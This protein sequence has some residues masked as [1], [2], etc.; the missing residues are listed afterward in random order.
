MP[1]ING[2]SEGNTPSIRKSDRFD[3]LVSVVTP[4]AR[5]TMVAVTSRRSSSTQ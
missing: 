4:A 5:R 1:E 3:T 2:E